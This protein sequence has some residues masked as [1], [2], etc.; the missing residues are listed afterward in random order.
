[1]AACSSWPL[2]LPQPLLYMSLSAW[3]LGIFM[4][5]GA[6]TTGHTGTRPRAAYFT[7][8]RILHAEESL[9]LQGAIA[10]AWREE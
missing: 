8:H 4:R 7:L 3:P 5:Q 6:T 1:M 10:P 2:L 9:H